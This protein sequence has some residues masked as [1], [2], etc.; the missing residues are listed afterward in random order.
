MVEAVTKLNK[1]KFNSQEEEQAENIRRLFLAMA[2]D[3]RVLLI[4]LADRLHNMRTLKH[5]PKEKQ[6]KKAKETL[7]IFAPLAGRLGISNIKVE[8]EDLAMKY[9]LSRGLRVYLKHDSQQARR[10]NGACQ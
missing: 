3:I 7:D 6:L 10:K 1:F 4:K 5:I 8:L 2:K 9:P